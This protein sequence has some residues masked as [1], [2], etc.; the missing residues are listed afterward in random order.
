MEESRWIFREIKAL[1]PEE[2]LKTCILVRDN[3]QAK[4][5][6]MGI[7]SHNQK[8]PQ[9]Q[10]LPVTCIDQ[11]HL[12]KRQECK[13]VLAYLRLLMNKHDN[14]SLKRIVQ[15]FVPRIGRRT[16]ERLKAIPIAKWASC[17]V[18][19]SIPY[20]IKRAILTGSY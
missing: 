2:R 4:F 5:I 8:Y 17:S 3:R 16:V 11:F 13:D 18:I 14:L 20:P 12:F 19:L 1:P 10:Q 15:R 6:W 9:D 7:T